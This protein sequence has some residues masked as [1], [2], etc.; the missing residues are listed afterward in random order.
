MRRNRSALR[1]VICDP[2]VSQRQ[3]KISKAIA[4]GLKE[5]HG[6]SIIGLKS[7]FQKGDKVE[8]E[9]SQDGDD[10]MEEDEEEESQE[11]EQVKEE[12]VASKK[13]KK[14]VQDKFKEKKLSN[15]KPKMTKKLVWF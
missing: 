13:N 14:R 11:E 5:K 8:G 6:S 12:E 2:V 9:G 10:Q 3:Q 4:D 15:A 7:L 1:K